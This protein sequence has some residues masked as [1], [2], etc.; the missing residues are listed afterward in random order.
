MKRPTGNTQRER[1]NTTPRKTMNASYDP[2]TKPRCETKVPASTETEHPRK[3]RHQRT[4]EKQN[5]KILTRRPKSPTQTPLCPF[6]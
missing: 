6:S 3:Q 1:T 4:P 5:D 2:R